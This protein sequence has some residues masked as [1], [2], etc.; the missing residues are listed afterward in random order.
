MCREAGCG[1]CAVSVTYLPPDSNTLKTYSVQSCLTPLYAVD[2]WQVTTVEG[3][4]SQREG[5]HPLQERIAKF[6]GTQCGYCTPGMVMNMYGLLHQKANISSQEIEDNFDGNLCRCT[7][8]RPVLDAMKSFAQD[9]NIPNRETIDIEDLN[10]KL[11]P[12][13][14]EECSNS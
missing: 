11:C 12:K 8:Y 10:K 9:A 2:G 13:T 6:N 5:F 3:L 4:G 1:C 14:G 7:G